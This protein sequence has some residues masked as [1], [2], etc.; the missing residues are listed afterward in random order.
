MRTYNL[1]PLDQLELE[2]RRLREEINISEQKMAF[3]LKYISDNWGSM[4]VKS[5]SSSIMNK[6]T[7]RVESSSP[8]STTSLLTRSIG[9]GLGSL[10]LSKYK[11]VGSLGW[12]LFKPMALAFITKKATTKLFSSK[13]KK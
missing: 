11:S 2:E 8:I 1:T 12:K 6:V 4:I 9:G 10:L 7:D 3:Q 5:I 13:K